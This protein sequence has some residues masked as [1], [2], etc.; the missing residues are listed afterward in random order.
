V[1][2]EPLE[3]E[4]KPLGIAAL[5]WGAETLAHYEQLRELLSS[6]LVIARAGTRV[7]VVVGPAGERPTRPAASHAPSSESVG[8]I[9]MLSGDTLAP[10]R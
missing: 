5:G 3:F 4:E 8:P 1:I 7:P 10:R 2:V 9:T 6:A